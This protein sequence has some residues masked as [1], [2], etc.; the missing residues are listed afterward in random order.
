[1]LGGMYLKEELDVQEPAREAKAPIF[2]VVTTNP[3]PPPPRK[4]EAGES[5]VAIVRGL[6][7]QSGIAESDLIAFI[8]EIGLADDND[9]CSTLDGTHASNDAALAMIINNWDDIVSRIITG[10]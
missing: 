7:E 1:M 5:P 8:K 6:C 9:Q 2:S 3:P 4:S 10:K